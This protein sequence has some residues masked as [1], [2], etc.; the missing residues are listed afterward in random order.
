MNRPYQR[1][2]TGKFQRHGMTR[3]T[4]H[5]AYLFDRPL[6]AKETDSEQ[7]LKTIAAL[8]RRGL[9]VSLI[10]PGVS[11][12]TSLGPSAVES[13]AAS[14]LELTHQLK[15]YYQLTGDFETLAVPNS[16]P[17][18]STPRKWQHAR[19]AIQVAQQLKPDVLYT[20]NFPTLFRLAK[21][22]L[23]FAY[24]TY[25]PWADQFPVL[26]PSFRSALGKPHCLGA[27][28][29][30][31]FA[32]SRYAAWGIDE[33]KL[34][35]VWNGY[36]PKYFADRPSLQQAR[37][38]LGLDQNRPLVVYTG[39]INA[40]KGLDMVWALAQRCPNVDFLLVGSEGNGLIERM[41]RRQSNIKT[42]PWQAFDR[43]VKYLF[44]ADVLLLP[45]SRIPLRVIGNTVL[46]M[47]LFLYLAAGRPI[48]APRAPDT[49]ELLR[50]ES[51]PGG[52]ALL[53]APGD[54][55]GA[56][57]ALQRLVEDARLATRLSNAALATSQGLTWDARAEKIEHFL[58]RRLSEV[59]PSTAPVPSIVE[60]FGTGPTGAGNA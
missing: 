14:N 4:V 22:S 31:Q 23:P 6:P 37:N 32:A 2:K 24:E 58:T 57:S 53:V 38:D 39:H 50:D 47:K 27:V 52:N 10:V 28:L 51:E 44:A 45:P 3:P 21:Q 42:V 59:T 41:S 55:T 8:A 48:L 11:P 40:T 35:V 20:R 33:A 12:S 54:V 46:P 15:S 13:P 36:D 60:G 30:S 5:I 19:R 49:R 18:W 34:T 9:R 25:R 43:T 1:S 56:A 26:R 29:H 16:Y 7:A 17:R